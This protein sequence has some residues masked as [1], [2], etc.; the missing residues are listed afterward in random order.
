[1]ALEATKGTPVTPP[2]AFLPVKTLSPE[3]VIKYVPVEVLQ[4]AFPKV[5]GD[6]PTYHNTSVEIGGPI[7][8]DTFG[9]PLFGILG[10]LTTSA[11]RSV[12]DGVLNSTTTVTSATAAFTSAD[13]GK[14]IGAVGVPSGAVI[15]SVTNA[16]TI[17][18]SQA[19]TTSGS[20]V[21]LV[22]GPTSWH[23][24][25]VL[26][27]VSGGG[28]PK[29]NTLYD[30]YNATNARQFAGVQWHE[31]QIKFSA[32]GLLEHT[33]KATG[34]VA[35][36]QVAKPTQSFTA[37]TPTPSWSGIVTIGGTVVSTVADGDVTITRTMELVPTLTGTQ[38]YGSVW[39]GTIEVKF[40]LSL[41][42]DL[43]DT[44]Y[45]RFVGNTQPS[46]DLNFTVGAGLTAQ[47]LVIHT[48]KA[49][50]EKAKL[51]RGKS[52]VAWDCEGQ[53]IGNTT[54]VGSS[55][56]YGVCTLKLGNAVAASTYQ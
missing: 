47:Q 40:K 48:T 39:I 21:T 45:L 52:W 38:Q 10:D 50:Y 18:L 37:I 14:T 9:W 46:L 51:N 1:V 16:T 19:A 36:V 17:V 23:V 11:S 30:Y 54:D 33:S 29:S 28:Q 55:G 53:F 49:A 32:E 22:I 44:E 13:V 31:T 27:S 5:Y 41:V 6:I 26:N 2:S 43:T 3:D 42:A 7:F 35:S 24:G 15:Q 8:A 34:L 4:G 56:G 20:G 25:N 12:S